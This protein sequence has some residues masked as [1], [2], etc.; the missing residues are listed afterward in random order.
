MT[1]PAGAR[2]ATRVPPAALWFI[3]GLLGASAG[4]AAAVAW[5]QVKA[6]R[7]P[8]GWMIAPAPTRYMD[9]S[10]LGE[11]AVSP[12]AWALVQYRTLTSPPL[13]ELAFTMTLPERGSLDVGNGAATLRLRTGEAPAGPGGCE[14]NLPVVSTAPYPLRLRATVDSIEASSQGQT[15]RCRV[16]TGAE[17]VLTPGLHRLW[18]SD[19]V[20]GG[21]SAAPL[22]PAAHVLA[23]AVG[24]AGLIAFGAATIA[25]GGSLGV[26]AL[27]SLPLGFCALLAGVDL[28]GLRE[29]LRLPSLPT[30]WASLAAGVVP[31]ALAH[32]AALGGSWAAKAPSLVVTLFAVAIAT[33]LVVGRDLS[34]YGLAIIGLVGVGRLLARRLAGPE[35]AAAA[36]AVLAL[37]A[38]VGV[39]FGFGSHPAARMYFA[40]AGAMVGALVWLTV[41]AGRVRFY[42]GLSFLCAIVAL[43]YVELGVR[44]TEAGRFWTAAPVDAAG[45]STTVESF[46]ALEGATSTEYPSS[47]Y[48]VRVPAKGADTRI[49]CLGGSSTGGA[50]QEDDLGVFY[51]ARLD[52]VLGAGVE[53]VNQGVGAWSSFHI[54]LFAE[55]HLAELQPDVVTLYVGV[56]EGTTSAMTYV[57]LHRRWKAGTLSAGPGVLEELRLFNG[58]RFLVRGLSANPLDR[59]VPAEDFADD[60]ATIAAAVRAS[61]A[62][63]LLLSEAMQPDPISIAEYRAVM[64]SAAG[65]DLAYLDTAAF[66]TNPAW[67]RD[68]NHLTP[69]GHDALAGLIAAELQRLGWIN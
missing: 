47:G 32:V 5:G 2:P 15:M 54:A 40:L 66:V 31:A 45:W 9:P 57:E 11:L 12:G 8:P 42:N 39:V 49:V 13:S 41:H 51:P 27:A 23:L 61:G 58:L 69:A 17:F 1:E 34:L 44:F 68:T 21:A 18:V 4:H 3:L 64:K 19:L 52:A 62:K 65:G 55:R 6:E 7:G 60:V 63:L 48:P 25:S 28:S 67:F 20:G 59:A 35:S 24:A 33:A 38:A 22:S 56:N 14:G 53:A 16:T 43:G 36:A 26:A 10:L 37:G 50:W 29:V 46:R 30:Q